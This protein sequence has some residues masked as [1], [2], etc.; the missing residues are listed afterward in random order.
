[1][2]ACSGPV[3]IGLPGLGSQARP[4]NPGSMAPSSDPSSP[5]TSSPPPSRQVLSLPSSP[6]TRAAMRNN[7]YSGWRVGYHRKEGRKGRGGGAWFHCSSRE[8]GG[9]GERCPRK[10]EAG[11]N[12]RSVGTNWGGGFAVVAAVRPGSFWT[13]TLWQALRQVFSRILTR[14]TLQMRILSHS[15]GSCW[16]SITQPVSAWHQS[17]LLLSLCCPV[18]GLWR[19]FIF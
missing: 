19:R 16:Q 12:R 14:P 5:L 8:I 10:A 3:A 18:Y 11:K 13:L 9:V 4:L 2:A 1:M 15:K 6:E 7:I 17:P